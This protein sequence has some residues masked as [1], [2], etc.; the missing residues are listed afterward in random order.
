MKKFVTLATLAISY[1]FLISTASG[2][3]IRQ[4]LAH[5]PHRQK[6]PR[7]SDAF[8]VAA[9]K[10]TL[11]QFK[12]LG[13]PSSTSAAGA[14]R[15]VTGSVRG[16]Q[17]PIPSRTNGSSVRKPVGLAIKTTPV[18]LGVSHAPLG[19]AVAR[20]QV[21]LGKR[22][23]SARP[24]S[25]P[26]LDSRA[27]I[28]V[29]FVARGGTEEDDTIFTRVYYFVYDA[30]NGALRVYGNRLATPAEASEAHLPQNPIQ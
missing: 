21:G 9:S 12:F 5:V 1:A 11:E 22:S 25:T 29:Q 26:A 30:T 28:Q 17:A 2:A 7:I 4:S 16:Q 27:S 20:A 10:A 6:A 23:A 3:M 8:L 19:A 13:V 18:F 14:V 24:A 15:V